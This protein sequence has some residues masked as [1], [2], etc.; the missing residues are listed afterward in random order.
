MGIR[1]NS[2][3][4]EP[5]AMSVNK[6]DIRE[7]LTPEYDK[8]FKNGADYIGKVDEA[9][10]K[11]IEERIGSENIRMVAVGFQVGTVDVPL[12]KRYL[13]GTGSRIDWQVIDLNTYA[14]IKDDEFGF[15]QGTVRKRMLEGYEVTH[16]ALDDS[17]IAAEKYRQIIAFG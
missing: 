9:A 7:M 12:T 10:R 2:L 17:H 6:I 16:K 5:E 11:W 14:L 3:L 13:K 1:Y 4:V 15:E 8:K